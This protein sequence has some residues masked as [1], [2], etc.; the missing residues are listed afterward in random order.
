MN[1]R[2]LTSGG[3]PV[4]TLAE[5]RPPVPDT[6]AEALDP[7]WL[8]AASGTSFPGVE[9]RSVTPGPVVSRVSTNA[10]FT[11][12]CADG[13]P[14]GLSPHLCVKGYFTDLGQGEARAC[15]RARG[16]LLPRP[17][18]PDWRA[19]LRAVYA[20]LDEATLASVVITE[21]VVAD[22]ATFLDSLS[23][24]SPEQTA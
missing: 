17:R 14:D 23:E 20:D 16:V 9:V 4:S 11:I 1:G 3:V 5:T 21:D 19:T 15:R 24:Y 6:L 8:T 10:R 13:L 7:A 18:R 2:D 12:D 22:G